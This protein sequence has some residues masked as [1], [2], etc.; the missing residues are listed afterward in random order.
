MGKFSESTLS[1][2]TKPASTTEED[3]INNAVNM[4]KTAINNDANFDNLS[5]EVLFKGLMETILM[6]ELTVILM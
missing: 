5:Y 3:K 6:L 2:W 1:S 4:I